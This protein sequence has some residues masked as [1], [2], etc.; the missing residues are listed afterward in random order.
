ML[1]DV[2]D[3]A[4]LVAAFA[5]RTPDATALEQDGRT[6]SYRILHQEA[7][8]TAG[9]LRAF[10]Q[11]S[12]D[13]WAL[14]LPR[15]DLV[16]VM[17][18]IGRLGGAVMPL[19]PDYPPERVDFMIRDA[20]PRC[21]I[22]THGLA[23]RF[24]R[25]S[26]PV[27]TLES[28]KRSHLQRPVSSR[29]LV[30]PHDP[31][32]LVY[33]SGSTG[34]PKG[35]LIEHASLGPFLR[36][37]RAAARI[38]S[39]SRI[40]AVASSSFDASYMETLVALG[41]GA[42]LVVPATPVL[43][44]SLLEEFLTANNITHVFGPPSALAALEPQSVP[45]LE[46]VIA[47]GEQLSASLARRWSGHSTVLNIYGPT[48]TTIA[49][50]LNPID[51]WSDVNYPPPLGFPISGTQVLVL[52]ER[53]AAVPDGAVGELYILGES[54]GRG[55]INRPGLTSA[56]FVAC[57]EAPGTRMYRTGD[58]GRRGPGG[59]L[60]F[61]GRADEQIKLHGFRIEPGEVQ[62]AIEAY[63]GVRA[64]A[65]VMREDRPGDRILV[66][67]IVADATTY[68]GL[69]GWLADRL[70][71]YLLPDRIVTL[72]RLP[73]GANGKLDKA[74]LPPAL[75][76]ADHRAA[77]RV[78]GDATTGP[79]ASGLRP[80]EALV[81]EIWCDVLGLTR[82]NLDDNFFDLGGN[83]MRL[84]QV[85]NQLRDERGIKVSAV[86]LFDYS[87]IRKLAGA[88]ADR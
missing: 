60:E 61:V 77:P 84:I 56:S 43:G 25:C 16:R 31:A 85:R 45:G 47:G 27:I 42:T 52:D 36:A 41:T 13:I 24:A 62:A 57:A 74:A 38:S 33:T 11:D 81:H 55:Y 2:A 18:A 72:D 83:S 49:V 71:R 8:R 78:T 4:G 48:E 59:R 58:V 53:L 10:G 29:T 66:A 88:L 67:Y 28:L 26:V 86:D 68:D 7:G 54:L 87:T 6:T 12:E 35:V 75:P 69:R 64:A 37:A 51:A 5:V 80:V 19:D 32:Y 22:T 79:P 70:P 14:A 30:R 23:S 73:L 46:V 76:R 20:R 40:A 39:H 50:T 34:V 21:V 63:P 65:V 1:H 44:G 15:A 9:L 3:L 82:I 17:V